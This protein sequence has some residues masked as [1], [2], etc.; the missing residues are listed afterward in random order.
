MRSGISAFIL[1]AVAFGAFGCATFVDGAP[2]MP[3]T[4]WHPLHG[5]EEKALVEAIADYNRR[6]GARLRAVRRSPDFFI[7]GVED[8][9]AAGRGPD[10]FIWAHDVVGSLA[11]RG[12]IAPFESSLEKVPPCVEAVTWK[13]RSWALPF[14]FETLILYYN[15]S[16]VATPPAST[17]DLIR[18]G[19]A[20][21]RERPGVYGLVYDRTNLYYHAAWLHGFGGDLLDADGVFNPT[22]PAMVRSLEFARDL[23]KV[24]GIAPDTADWNRQ[25][26][27]F[28]GGQAAMLISGPWAYGH[29]ATLG[30]DLGMAPL[31]IVSATGL[32]AR[33]FL[34]VKA[35]YLS[36][37]SPRAQTARQAAEFLASAPYASRFAI[38]TGALPAERTAY[39]YSAVT[40]DFVTMSFKEQVERTRIMPN[41]PD[42]RRVWPAM[43]SDPRTGR[44]GALERILVDGEDP[45]PVLNQVLEEFRRSGR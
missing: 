31:P 22:T 19:R 14:A 24:H 36:A 23:V 3:I 38:M 15:R 32:P 11:E 30:P 16:L 26:T 28:T 2:G 10:L 34:G 39:D 8:A 25:M 6:G 45:L 35:F 21:R 42:M 4:I 9:L 33:P 20:I 27:L 43:M 44:C 37:T 13:G 5:A 17:D 12:L 18:I 7:D 1:L 41:H 40:G 29:V